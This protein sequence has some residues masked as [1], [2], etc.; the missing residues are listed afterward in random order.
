MSTN[1]AQLCPKHATYGVHLGSDRT[2][3]MQLPY[4][5]GIWVTFNALKVIQNQK[6]QFRCKNAPPTRHRGRAQGF[7]FVNSR[8][9]QIRFSITFN[10]LKVTQNPFRPNFRAREPQGFSFVKSRGPSGAPFVPRLKHVCST[11]VHLE[12]GRT[13][14]YSARICIRQWQSAAD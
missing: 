14:R 8:T 4:R 10:T 11:F 1:V 3:S 6:L 9:L 2:T 7:S 13:P 5:T 12:R